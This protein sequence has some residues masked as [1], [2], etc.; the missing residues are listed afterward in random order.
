MGPEVA[1][2][3]V[4]FFEVAGNRRFVDAAK[5]AGL[6]IKVKER[7]QGP[8]AGRVFC[9]TG[10]L[11]SVTRDQAKALAE[12]QGANTSSSISKKVTD[13]VLGEAAGTKAEKAKKLGL[14]MMDEAEFLALVGKA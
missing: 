10:G 3:I 8:L 4:R 6:K 14:N 2:S 12:A 1:R 9:F 7:Q 11:S 13:V 5:K